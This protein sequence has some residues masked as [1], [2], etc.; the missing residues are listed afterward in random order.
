MARSKEIHSSQI[1]PRMRKAEAREFLEQRWER[2]E[3]PDFVKDDPIAIPQQFALKEDKEIIGFVTAT[4][5]WGN[6]KSIMTNALSL[7]QRMDGAPHA[8][9]TGASDQEMRSLEGFVHRTF[10]DTD[11]MVFVSALRHLYLHYDGLEG[12]FTSAFR[13][14]GNAAGAIAC[15][16]EVFFEVEH[17]DRTGKHVANPLKGSS[18]KRINMFLRW[19]VRSSDRGVDFGLWKEIDTALLEVPLDVH[20]GN[21]ARRLGLLTRKQNDRKAV[22]ELMTHLRRFDVKDPVKYDFA[23]FGAGVYEGITSP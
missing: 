5:A 12:V 18:A 15:F 10:N 8:F 1:T 7:V 13:Q 3:R 9:V 21:V 6:R 17:P 2:Y 16:R 19:M 23:L 11:L 4:I 14:E 22:E 20:T